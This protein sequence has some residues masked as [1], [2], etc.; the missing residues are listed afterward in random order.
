MANKVVVSFEGLPDPLLDT[1]KTILV[2]LEGL[3]GQNPGIDNIAAASI[4]AAADMSAFQDAI[5]ATGIEIAALA[6]TVPAV[7][8]AL[9]GIGAVGTDAFTPAADAATAAAIALAEA[10]ASAAGAFTPA[11]DAIGTVESAL[12]NVAVAGEGVL[13]PAVASI[14]TAQ[15]AVVPLTEELDRLATSLQTVVDSDPAVLAPVIEAAPEATGALGELHAELQTLAETLSQAQAEAEAFAEEAARVDEAAQDAVKTLASE[16]PDEFREALNGL[17]AE[18]EESR[19][20]FERLS[21]A[22]GMSMQSM[23]GWATAAAAAVG[24][25]KLAKSAM[26]ALINLGTDSVSEWR[27]QQDEVRKLNAVLEATGNVTGFTSDQLINHAAQLELVTTVGGDAIIGVQRLVATF[28]NIRGDEFLRATTLSL[29]MAD[30]MGGDAQAAALHLAKALQDPLHGMGALSRAGVMF[31][32]SQKEVI[33]SMIDTGDIAGAQR[34]ILDQLDGQFGGT[35]ATAAGTF[36]GTMANLGHRLG[37]VKEKI[38]ILIEQGLALLGPHLSDAVTFIENVTDSLVAS[39]EEFSGYGVVVAGVISSVKTAVLDGL[40][41]AFVVLEDRLI[42]AGKYSD[43]FAK[44]NALALVEIGNEFSYIFTERIPAYLNWF[45]D[46]FMNMLTDWANMNKS[47]AENM[48]ENWKNLFA[49]LMSWV[50]GDGFNFEWTGLL[51][52]FERTVEALPEIAARKK[53]ELEKALSL[54]VSGL[55]GDLSTGFEARLEQR[56]K[57]LESLFTPVTGELDLTNTAQK[58]DPADFQKKKKEEKEK[59]EREKKEGREPKAAT[60]AEP[61]QE[62]GIDSRVEG[63]EAL[64]QRIADAAAS[65]GPEAQWHS[66][67]INELQ[68]IVKAVEKLNPIGEKTFSLVPMQEALMPDVEHAQA[69]GQAAAEVTLPTLDDVSKKLD[70]FIAL[71]QSVARAL[72]L[73]G[74]LT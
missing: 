32:A 21:E 64:Y 60:A 31:S 48:Y 54:E 66:E 3:D 73:R 24:A 67:N 46:N 58:V 68:N 19:G 38:G 37:G 51:K 63:A 50:S 42:N 20:L 25:A 26:G 8:A 71:A 29:D 61:E 12:G 70:T 62:K 15:S 56:R 30:A 43:L 22:T 14:A 65:T 69:A 74:T 35:A 49:A 47:V 33:Q 6:S 59:E 72:P 7:E 28:K 39:A 5:S 34:V 23:L 53:S 40:V 44:Q 9:A 17:N 57:Q 36:A 10:G 11:T 13:A 1:I 18:A 2:A 4:S 41:Y 52:G 45:G 27:K 16:A 55:E